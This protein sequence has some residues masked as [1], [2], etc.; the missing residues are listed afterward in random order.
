MSLSIAAFAQIEGV[1]AQELASTTQGRYQ[2]ILGPMTRQDTYLLDTQTGQVWRLTTMTNLKA[3]P[4]VW[5]IMDKI[6]NKCDYEHL[7]SKYG[8]NTEAE[9]ALSRVPQKNISRRRR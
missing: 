4:D 8:M 1:R 5:R 9:K 7:V 3:E 6:D 2:I